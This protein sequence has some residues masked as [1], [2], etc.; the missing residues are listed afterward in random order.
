MSKRYIDN[1]LGSHESKDRLVVGEME[2]LDEPIFTICGKEFCGAKSLEW[3]EEAIKEKLER[4][5][6]GE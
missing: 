1:Y 2:I 3:L 6:R 5:K 4:E